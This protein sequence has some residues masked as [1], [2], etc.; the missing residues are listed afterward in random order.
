LLPPQ[1]A[2]AA[3]VPSR[4]NAIVWMHTRWRPSR[5]I[6]RPVV[7]SHR[8]IA[9]G[10]AVL[11]PPADARNLPSGEKTTE[12]TYVSPVTFS[13]SGFPEATSHKR[14]AAVSGPS[15]VARVLPSGEKA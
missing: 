9:Y 13:Q 6:S 7:G 10:S 1:P 8:R 15:P 3:R 11:L 5:R 12:P 4:E 14:T 2:E